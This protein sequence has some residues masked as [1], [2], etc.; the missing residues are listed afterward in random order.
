M[1]LIF[2]Y[3]QIVRFFILILIVCLLKIYVDS[4]RKINVGYTVGL[5]IFAS[6]L[7]IKCFVSFIY[8]FTVL[9]GM[10][11]P[12]IPAFTNN[13]AIESTIELIAISVLYKITRE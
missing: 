4:Y 6:V 7:F 13:M 9:F 12:L 3:T 10:S 2:C 5:L 8:S 1:N 11:Y